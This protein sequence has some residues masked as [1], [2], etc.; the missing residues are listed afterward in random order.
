MLHKAWCTC[1]RNGT[2]APP[3][4]KT[5]HRGTFFFYIFYYATFSVNC[6]SVLRSHTQLLFIYLFTLHFSHPNTRKIL[7]STCCFPA[8]FS[9][10]NKIRAHARSFDVGGGRA[11][12]WRLLKSF[13]KILDLGQAES[14]PTNANVACHL[15]RR[16]CVRLRGSRGL[17]LSKHIT[18]FI[19]HAEWGA[20]RFSRYIVVAERWKALRRA[21]P[22]KNDEST[23]FPSLA[24]TRGLNSKKIQYPIHNINKWQ[25]I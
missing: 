4:R 22:G 12:N 8:T 21:C 2:T 7:A 3:N 17:R 13:Q 24:Q 6:H 1:Q 23:R 5:H 9:A 20:F 16:K 18:I 25:K 19:Y 10:V 11:F 14:E 15:F